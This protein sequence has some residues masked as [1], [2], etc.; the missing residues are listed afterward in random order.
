MTRLEGAHNPLVFYA[1]YYCDFALLA[2]A[3]R[4]AGFTGR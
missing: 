1:G 3:L 4:G 2:K